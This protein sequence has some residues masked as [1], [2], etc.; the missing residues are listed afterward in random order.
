MTIPADHAGLRLAMSTRTGPGGTTPSLAAVCSDSTAHRR[1]SSLPSADGRKDEGAR[2]RGVRTSAFRALSVSCFGASSVGV[3][4]ALRKG[5]CAR[6]GP[7]SAVGPDARGA[8]AGPP[9]DRWRRLIA[10]ARPSERSTPPSR[11]AAP[12]PRSVHH[13][14]AGFAGRGSDLPAHMSG[15]KGRCAM[16]MRPTK[17]AFA[18]RVGPREADSTPRR[19]PLSHSSQTL[20][21]QKP[22]ARK[23]RSSR[24]RSTER[25]ELG[26]PRAQGVSGRLLRSP[27]AVREL[28]RGGLDRRGVTG[29]R[30]GVYRRHRHHHPVERGLGGG[31]LGFEPRGP[32]DAPGGRAAPPPRG[33]ARA[34]AC[35][36]LTTALS[37]A[38]VAVGPASA[39]A[40][41]N[42]STPLAAATVSAR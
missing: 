16:Q 26:D 30:G 36:R 24:P 1:R 29:D 9:A 21:A 3:F 2:A 6:R 27:T 34:G 35:S 11:R 25:P 41:L 10:G 38:A 20:R 28:G 33:S 31:P 12:R 40:A 14:S 39:R 37:L 22:R 32:R 8:P 4:R 5:E 17:G 42:S 18:R 23:R 7:A 13:T 15:P 19:I